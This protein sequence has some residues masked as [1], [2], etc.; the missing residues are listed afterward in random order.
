MEELQIDNASL[1]SDASGVYVQ[2]LEQG[3]WVRF[4]SLGDSANANRYIALLCALGFD[5]GQIE[6]VSGDWNTVSKQRDFGK[7][8]CDNLPW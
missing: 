7:Q 2:H 8:N 1:V 5:V 4:N 3:G 6:L